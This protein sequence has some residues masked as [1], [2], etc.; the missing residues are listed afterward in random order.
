MFLLFFLLI[1]LFPWAIKNNDSM[2]PSIFIEENSVGYYQ[3]NTCEFTLFETFNKNIN[4]KNI[5][6]LVDQNSSVKCFGKI[7]GVDFFSNTSKVYVGTNLNVDFLLQSLTILFLISKIPKTNKLTKNNNSYI[8]IVIISSLVFL[9]LKGE[10]LYYEYFVK[11]FNLT[12]E[13]NN[14]FIFSIL[15]TCIFM[16][17]IFNDLL[18]DRFYNFINYFPFLFLFVGTFNTLN[19]NIFVILISFIGVKAHLERKVNKLFLII[20]L[21]FSTI[22]IIN[23]NESNLLFDVDKLK[24][25]INSSQTINSLIYW[26]IIFYLLITGVLYLINQSAEYFNLEIFI[27]NFLVTGASITIIGYLGA[28][29]PYINFFSYYYLGLNK[30]GIKNLES[31]AGNTWRGV[32]SSAEALG[33]IY[34]FIFAELRQSGDIAHSA[35]LGG[36]LGSFLSFLFLRQR[37]DF[38]V[39][40]FSLRASPN[41]NKASFKLSGVI[42]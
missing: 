14:Y 31:V 39:V 20:Y 13:S 22:Q 24:G 28:I 15:L 41:D 21:T 4:N 18:R 23:F 27:R 29:N 17:T 32:G 10:K 19:L 34:G 36:M 8:G 6:V 2:L 38:P 30:Y 3:T 35:H 16:L 12:L 33:E 5:E 26:I 9:H 37:K 25:F 1:I 11:N 40:S 7:N 42:S